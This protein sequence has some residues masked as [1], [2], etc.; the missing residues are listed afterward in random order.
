MEWR[1]P[2]L[3]NMASPGT[4]AWLLL[5]LN[6]LHMNLFF[7]VTSLQLE[8]GTAVKQRGGWKLGFTGGFLPDPP[9]PVLFMLSLRALLCRVYHTVP[10]HVLRH[11]RE[12]E[13]FSVASTSLK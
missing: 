2:S 11:R 10:L 12:Q 7:H 13:K 8:T 3:G 1:C 6:F 9:Y 4:A 5:Q